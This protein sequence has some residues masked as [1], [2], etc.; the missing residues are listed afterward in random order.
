[1]TDDVK[2]LINLTINSTICKLKIDGF[3]RDSLNFYEKT[4]EILKNFDVLSKSDGEKTKKIMLELN[5]VM[6]QLINDPYFDVIPMLYFGERHTIAEVAEIMGTSE[7]TI[8]R[9]KRR[10]IT[11]ISKRLFTDDWLLYILS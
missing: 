10:L 11:E 6:E 2:D 3:L 7:R 1:M 4:E 9:H 5:H 8:K